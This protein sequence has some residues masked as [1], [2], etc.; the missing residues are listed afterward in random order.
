VIKHSDKFCRETIRS[1]KKSDSGRIVVLG[2][3][4][5]LLSDE[6]VGVHAATALKE[7]FS[8]TP[9]IDII[10]GGTMGLDLLPLF[11]ERDRI[12]IIDAV[13]FR[14]SP[15]HTGTVEGDAIAA[16]LNTKLSAHHIG[17]ADLLFTA[18]L[19]RET[20]FELHLVGIQPDSFEVGLALT[21]RV[22]HKL[23]III[24]MAVR[25]LRDWNIAVS[26]RDTAISAVTDNRLN[27]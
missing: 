1:D 15:G 23:D 17:L 5:I 9:S 24:E 13:D 25:K 11:Q 27:H 3:G 10:D 19:T 22:Q 2:L 12:L 7:R 6:G 8:F 16:V 4:N 14:K 20:P 26:R 18:K 21:N